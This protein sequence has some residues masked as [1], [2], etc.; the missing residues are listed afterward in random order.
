MR[1]ILRGK[2]HRTMAVWPAVTQALSSLPDEQRLCDLQEVTSPGAALQPLSLAGSVV[3]LDGL[4]GQAQAAGAVEQADVSGTQVIDLRPP[5]IFQPES[6]SAAE[7]TVAWKMGGP[8][9]AAVAWRGLVEEKRVQIVSC[10]RKPVSLGRCSVSRA[11][12]RVICCTATQVTWPPQGPVGPGEPFPHELQ[13]PGPR[14]HPLSCADPVRDSHV[15]VSL[16][17]RL[18]VLLPG[19]RRKV[20]HDLLHA[21]REGER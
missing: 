14:D 7:I 9:A 12:M 1:G 18:A 4:E 20:E 16:V 15:V 21:S 17:Y 3:A 6:A 19:G 8:Y 10:S 13:R 2:I 11:G 5:P